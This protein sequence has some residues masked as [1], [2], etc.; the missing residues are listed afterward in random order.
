M[1]ALA[2]PAL[3]AVTPW[4][5]AGGTDIYMDPVNLFTVGP[6]AMSNG[7]VWS[8]TNSIDQGGAVFGWTNGYSFLG[9]GSWNGEPAMAGTNQ[10]SDV[11]GSVQS[12]SF[13][14]TVALSAIGGVIN[15]VPNALPVTISI[16]D[17][18]DN[19]LDSLVMSSG[20]I[21]LE[22]PDI[23]YGFQSDT[24]NIARLT[25]TDGYIGIRSIK[26][27]GYVAD[28]GGIPEPATWA[29]MIMGFGMTGTAMRASRRRRALAT[30]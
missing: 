13:D 5:G 21:N 20:G 24:A 17:A 11:Y 1:A 15:W 9:N 7:L 27:I 19:L 3:A 23:F 6:V 30:A 2:A 18:G 29:M 28:P 16:Y 10:S 25:L 12:M 8:S 26:A 4:N 14:F 22:T